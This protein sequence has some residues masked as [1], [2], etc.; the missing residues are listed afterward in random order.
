MSPGPFD[1]NVA[2]L[3]LLQWLRELDWEVRTGASISPGEPGAERDDYREV[4][5]RRRLRK[6][7]SRLNPELPAAPLEAAERKLLRQESPSVVLDNRRFHRMLVHGVE[8]EVAADGRVKGE[9]VRVADLE[10]PSRNDW[11]AVNQLTIQGDERPRRADVVL[12]VNGLPVGLVELKNPA[13]EDATIWDAFAQ[14]ETYKHELPTLFLQNELL[15]VSD[16]VEARLGTLTSSQE[17][18]LPWRTIDG[19]ELAPPTANRLEV[20]ARGVFAHATVLDLLRSFVVFEDDGGRVQK[21]VAGYHQFHAT[22]KAIET[23]L[24][25][26]APDG[27]RRAG[28][29]WHTQARARA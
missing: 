5:L 26:A 16:G 3:A 7:L 9:H 27:D 22:R 10:D 17:W 25:A 11:L 13:D 1:E 23:T 28:V 6:A 20:L 14:L 29:V 24:R 12:Y 18:F 4:V 19:V 8:I 21:K 15:V 2:E